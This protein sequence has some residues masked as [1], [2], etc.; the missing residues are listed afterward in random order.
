[1]TLAMTAIENA[2]MTIAKNVIVKLKKV[3]FKRGPTALF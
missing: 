1:M 2:T 3:R